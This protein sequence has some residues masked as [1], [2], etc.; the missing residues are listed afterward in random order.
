MSNKP[1]HWTIYCIILFTSFICTVTSNESTEDFWIATLLG[2]LVIG[3][4]YCL[5]K[6][7]STWKHANE[8][9]KNPESFVKKKV[10][11]ISIGKPLDLS[12][13]LKTLDKSCTT[14][15]L[16]SI[17][18]ECEVQGDWDNVIKLITVDLIKYE[19]VQQETIERIVL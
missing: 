13:A 15:Y 2:T 11:T 16:D 14:Q 8:V 10:D 3:T 4:P 9:L 17:L 12:I 7:S 6:S 5:G 19:K 1:K 18:A